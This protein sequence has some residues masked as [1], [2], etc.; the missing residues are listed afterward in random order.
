MGI[1][2][3]GFPCETI[4]LVSQGGWGGGSSWPGMEAKSADRGGGGYTHPR[5]PNPHL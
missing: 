2:D 3:K 4:L 1:V 5:V